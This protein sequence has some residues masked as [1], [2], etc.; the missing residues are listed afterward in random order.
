MKSSPQPLSWGIDWDNLSD[1]QK[2]FLDFPLLGSY[3][4]TQRRLF[5]QMKRR[6]LVDMLVWDQ[7]SAEVRVLAFQ[8]AETLRESIEWPN[9]YFLPDDPAQIPFWCFGSDMR[10]VEALI[11][12]ESILGV[13]VPL[14]FWEQCKTQTF[15]EFIENMLAR[16]AN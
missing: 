3:P 7:Y 15:A 6:R 12:I 9:P 5:A 2:M 8:I 10:D 16:K 11:G 4:R 1:W 13:A 14:D